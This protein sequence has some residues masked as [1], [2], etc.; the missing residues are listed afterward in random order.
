MY[1]SEKVGSH[2]IHLSCIKLLP[3]CPPSAGP[4]AAAAVPKN[5]CIGRRPE[6][7][8]PRPPPPPPSHSFDTLQLT[9]CSLS[10]T[11]DNLCD[12]AVFRLL[13]HSYAALISESLNKY[14]R[15][16]NSHPDY[17]NYMNNTQKKF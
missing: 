17:L 12:A 4:P 16:I 15:I 8:A 6:V 11:S 5:V 7:R 13:Y 2:G 3:D 10:F 14:L 1:Y 9:R